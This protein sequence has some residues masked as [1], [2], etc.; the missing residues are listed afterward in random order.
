MLLDDVSASSGQLT[1][2]TA[3]AILVI[4]SMAAPPALTARILDLRAE[5]PVVVW[6]IHER[7]AL[8]DD[9][10]HSEITS[11]GA[12]VGTPQL[13]NLLQRQRRR[14]AVV[15]GRARDPA[16]G[17][18]VGRALRAAAAAR[19]LHGARMGRVGVPL[20]GYG[21][22]D[23]ED[24]ELERA[25]GL[26]VVP[27]QAEALRQRYARITDAQINAVTME[28]RGD[29]CIAAEL[30][31]S[32]G[33][34][35]SVRFAAALEELDTELGLDMGAMNCH[36]PE[37]RFAADPGIAP[38]FALGRET[39]RGIPWSCTGDV[40]APIAMLVGKLLSGCA[41][42]HEIEALDYASNEALLANSGE[43]D[44]G[45]LPSAERPRL[46]RNPWFRTD[47]VCGACAT[48]TPSAGPATLLAFTPHADEPSG[49]RFVAAEGELTHRTFRQTGTFNA[50][51]RFAAHG[52]PVDRAWARWAEAG[53]NHHAALARGHLAWE[54]GLIAQLSSVGFVQVT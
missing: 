25:L 28:I 4:Q 15:L 22:V 24:R 36:V 44:L 11:E 26:A 10:G 20:A 32:L 45:W 53:V 14:S 21:C 23:A 8:P 19:R 34:S 3:E 29:F 7:D 5:L 40:L 42:Y 6:A 43:H 52:D 50:A 48:Y 18:R 49:F 27:V 2:A 16:C 37:L 38:C 35:R 30:E 39:S 31:G 33:L 9:F 54:V 12:T 13:L 46:H 17:E 41:I 51:F 1:D 47:E